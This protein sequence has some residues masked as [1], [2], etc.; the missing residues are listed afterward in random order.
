[1]K[2][3]FLIFLL[4]ICLSCQKKQPLFIVNDSDKIIYFTYSPSSK[5]KDYDGVRIYGKVDGNTND[6]LANT[7]RVLPNE[8]IEVVDFPSLDQ[9]IDDEFGGKIYIYF[10]EEN[11][12]RKYTWQLIV[13]G[14]L[15]SKVQKYEKDDLVKLNWKL[16][17]NDK[18]SSK[19]NIF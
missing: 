15:Y 16:K 18:S 13:N 7:S 19:A 5:L 10:F 1:M 11:T 9:V 17:Y 14:K 12:L 4:L 6:N 2:E 3:R 8:T